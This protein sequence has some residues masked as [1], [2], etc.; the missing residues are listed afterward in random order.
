MINRE[1][2]REGSHD[3]SKEFY[4]GQMAGDSISNASGAGG[5]GSGNQSQSYTPPRPAVKKSLA[6]TGGPPRFNPAEDGSGPKGKKK[7]VSGNS[8]A[9]GAR[10]AETAVIDPHTRTAMIG[11][12]MSQ[13]GIRILSPGLFNFTFITE[14]RLGNNLLKA[15][16]P[17]IGQ[18]TNL[19]HL[20]LA[21]NQIDE[22]PKEIGWLTDLKD[23]LLYNNQLSDLPPEMGYL[24]QLETLGLDGNPITNDGLLAVLHSQGPIACISFLRDHI[25]CICFIVDVHLT[26]LV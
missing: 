10:S 1:G 14:L 25:I 22:L 4:Q 3:E 12:D 8:G 23:L 18:L 17:S 11:L 21:N 5:M 15:L 16:P 24:Y 9:M 19:L 26:R 7:G 20:D 13:V 6:G 2:E